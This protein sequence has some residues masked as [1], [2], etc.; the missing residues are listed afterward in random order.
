[1]HGILVQV[2][3]FPGPFCKA[4]MLHGLTVKSLLKPC[5]VGQH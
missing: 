4:A 5:L 2:T 3:N 1:M